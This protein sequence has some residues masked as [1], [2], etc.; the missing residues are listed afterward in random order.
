MFLATIFVEKRHPYTRGLLSIE[1]NYGILTKNGKLYAVSHDD[2]SGKGNPE[3]K[4]VRFR[5]RGSQDHEYFLDWHQESQGT[6]KIT[7]LLPWLWAAAR[8]TNSRVLL[9]DKLDNSLH[10]QLAKA[11]IQGFL[12]TCTNRT[13]TQLI[14][15]T[16]DL[17]LMDCTDLLRRDEI[18]ITDKSIDGESTLIGL[19][20]YRGIMHDEDIRKSYLEGRFGGT[21]QLDSF[22]LEK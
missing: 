20:E 15:T 12:D 7:M 5:H 1:Q 22:T 16:H 6:Q 9:V 14:F 10:T 3:V 8:Q 11:L 17:L 2:H 21:P 4:Y 19:P 18:W 13:R